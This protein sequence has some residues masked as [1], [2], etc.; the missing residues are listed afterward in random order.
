MPKLTIS[1]GI[2]EWIKSWLRDRLQ[3]GEINGKRSGTGEVKTGVPQGSGLGSLLFIIYINDLEYSVVLNILRKWY[4]EA[5]KVKSEED[6]LNFQKALDSLVEWS[7][8]W[9]MHFNISNAK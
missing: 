7:K 3:Y 6:Y 5:S 2:Q 4:Q 1:P 9:G 8:D